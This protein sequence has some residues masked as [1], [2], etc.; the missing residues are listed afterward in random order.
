MT[1]SATGANAGV[2][3]RISIDCVPKPFIDD[4]TAPRPPLTSSATTCTWCDGPPGA[5]E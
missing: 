1:S 4:A 2:P 5:G 3:S